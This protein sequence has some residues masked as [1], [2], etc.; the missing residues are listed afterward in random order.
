MK[1]FIFVNHYLIF[2]SVIL[3]GAFVLRLN[4]LAAPIYDA[5]Y[6]RQTQTATVARNYVASGINLLRSELDIFGIGKERY[7]IMESPL[8]QA[9]VAL[10]SGTFGYS[11]MLARLVSIFS[12]LVSAVCLYY[13]V[14]ILSRSDRHSFSGGGQQSL[15]LLTATFFLFFPLNI[16][17]QRTVLIE[18]FV[19]MLHLLALV[20]WI[21][22]LEKLTPM[23]FILTLVVTILAVISKIIYGP[24]LLLFMLAIGYFKFDK[25]IIGR[26]WIWLFFITAGVGM[27]FWQITAN[28]LNILSGHGFFTSENPEHWLWN[29]GYFSE[30]LKLK[31]WVLRTNDVLGGITKLGATAVVFGSLVILFKKNKKYYLW[32]IWVGIMLVYYVFFFRIQSHIY[33]FLIVTPSL[34]ILAAIGASEG[35]KLINKLLNRKVAAFVIFI[36]IL[37]FLYKGSKNAQGY[38][39]LHTDVEQKIEILNREMTEPGPVVFIFPKWD[40]N[41]VYT[42]Y[43]GRKGVVMDYKNLDQLSQLRA[44]GYKYA[45]FIDFNEE[46][47]NQKLLINYSLHEIYRGEKVL[48]SEI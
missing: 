22:L 16:F 41:S 21:K 36:F 34:A 1:K 29:V 30:R 47:I 40:W 3:V 24:W 9:T 18:S 42:Y 17:F 11:E 44:Q 19:V 33:Y 25:K 45:V 6:F 31:A 20:F 10:L 35:Y 12:G 48:I 4:N 5:Y 13:L 28:K 32:L 2:L 43:T 23:L 8:Y 46:E 7:L 39:V 27:W 15:A 14:K 38:F 37:A 26:P